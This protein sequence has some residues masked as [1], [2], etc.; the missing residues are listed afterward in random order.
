[1]Q[2]C[3]RIIL[4][5]LNVQCMHVRRTL[6]LTDV[7]TMHDM[8]FEICITKLSMMRNTKQKSVIFM[9]FLQVMQGQMTWISE[10]G[11][12]SYVRKAP[13]NKNGTIF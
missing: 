9:R 6:N 4:H 8:E 12:T 13:C 2:E 10:D 11:V 3:T 7:M 5:V 1:M